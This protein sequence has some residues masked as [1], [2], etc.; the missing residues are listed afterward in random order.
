MAVEEGAKVQGKRVLAKRDRSPEIEV[1]CTRRSG[2]IIKG[3][4][5]GRRKRT[6]R[7]SGQYRPFR[8]RSLFLT[9]EE[10][11]QQV[12]SSLSAPQLDC[13]GDAPTCFVVR[14]VLE[15]APDRV[16]ETDA[17]PASKMMSCLNSNVSKSRAKN[18]A[19]PSRL[20]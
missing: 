4:C 10:V 6:S 13:I 2:E 9:T 20:L 15:L 8:C 18:V 7:A 19:V 12:R 1:L 14:A 5:Y 16:V 3:W 17:H 11:R